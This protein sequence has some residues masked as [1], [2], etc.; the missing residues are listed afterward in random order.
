MRFSNLAACTLTV[1]MAGEMAAQAETPVTPEP[2]PEG[3]SA[4]IAPRPELAEAAASERT[5]PGPGQEHQAQAPAQRFDRLHEVTPYSLKLECHTGAH[6]KA[7][8]IASSCH[9]SQSRRDREGNVLE[10]RD[11]QT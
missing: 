10:G 7:S 11:G 1:L 2:L 9:I 3:E 6:H 5:H 4:A 8:T